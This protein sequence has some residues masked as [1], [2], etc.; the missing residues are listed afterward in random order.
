V[1]DE[2]VQCA[3]TDGTED[4]WDFGTNVN[5]DPDPQVIY[6]G[7]LADSPD[8]PPNAPGTTRPMLY[9]R[10]SLYYARLYGG[11]EPPPAGS[12]AFIP[13]G[14]T[15]PRYWDAPRPWGKS[16]GVLRLPRM[17]LFSSTI[18]ANLV[19]AGVTAV[20]VTDWLTA[21]FADAIG[22]FNAALLYTSRLLGNGFAACIPLASRSEFLNGIFPDATYSTNALLYSGGEVMCI[23]LTDGLNQLLDG[24]TNEAYIAGPFL[25]SNPLGGSLPGP[26]P[27]ESANGTLFTGPVEVDGGGTESQGYAIG[28][29]V[30]AAADLGAG[31]S[32]TTSTGRTRTRSTSS[33]PPTSRRW[34]PG[35]PGS[36][37]AR[38]LLAILRGY[39]P[40]S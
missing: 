15:L 30:R 26:P 17:V 6:G 39:R 4:A 34:P 1:A 12:V 2:V 20:T 37:S 40:R 23:H 16:G 35:T 11:D 14:E 7:F 21:V 24:G 22:A 28:F 10:G 8:K 29:P 13:D 27:N 38:T 3:A 18:P 25:W 32:S 31:T 36:C 5:G 19:D 33:R 9:H